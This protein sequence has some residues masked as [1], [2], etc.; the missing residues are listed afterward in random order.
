MTSMDRYHWLL[1][2]SVR[3]VGIMFRIWAVVIGI[4]VLTDL[5]RLSHWGYPD[6][7]ILLIA[8][9]FAVGHYASRFARMALRWQRERLAQT[10]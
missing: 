6:W 2:H 8:I 9:F 3:I 4:F 10:R 7:A 1:L 5:F